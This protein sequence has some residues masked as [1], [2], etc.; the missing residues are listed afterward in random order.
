MNIDSLI[1]RIADIPNRIL[2]TTDG[3][4][5]EELRAR[6]ASGEWSTA[7]VLA[8]LRSGDDILTPRIYMMLVRDNPT[9]LAFEE[10]KW[11]EVMGYADADFHTSLQ[12]YIL[13]RAELVNVLQRLTP[14]EWQRT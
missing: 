6:P 10:R 1:N 2:R 7:D 14:E 13:K 9:L 5:E 3:W 8:H 12:T 4:S 11:A